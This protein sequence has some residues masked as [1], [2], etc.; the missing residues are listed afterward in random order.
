MLT[1]RYSQDSRN[2]QSSPGNAKSAG[3]AENSVLGTAYSVPGLFWEEEA[4]GSLWGLRPCKLPSL[5][6]PRPFYL[7]TES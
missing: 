7:A 1:L 2:F 4:E 5:L 3:G 6:L